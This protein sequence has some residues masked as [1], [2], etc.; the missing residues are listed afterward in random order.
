MAVTGSGVA[1]AGDTHR[2]LH[3]TGEPEAAVS[4]F[5]QW[6]ERWVG[7]QGGRRIGGDNN[8]RL[9]SWVETIAVRLGML[10]E[11]TSS[12]RIPPAHASS[13]SVKKYGCERGEIDGLIRWVEQPARQRFQGLQVQRLPGPA[14][15][16]VQT[17]SRSVKCRETLPPSG[18]SCCL[19]K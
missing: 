5:Q 1:V 16:L 6:A 10:P 11:G 13:H 18:A 19:T 9:G 8:V 2:A 12:G 17:L 15:S 4:V 14:F 7:I 3:T